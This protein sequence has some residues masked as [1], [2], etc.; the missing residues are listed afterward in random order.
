MWD[1]DIVHLAKFWYNRCRFYRMAHMFS[2][3]KYTRHDRMLSIPSL[4]IQTSVGSI[5]F[6]GNNT[7]IFMS[8]II[9]SLSIGSA[10]LS[11]LKDY[12]KFSKIETQHRQSYHGYSRL[13]RLIEKE[14]VLQRSGMESMDQKKFINDLCSQLELLSNDSPEIEE[15]ILN[16]V[17]GIET[18]HQENEL[19]NRINMSMEMDRM[20]IKQI[21]KKDVE[22][23]SD[24]LN[25]RNY[26]NV[27]SSMNIRKQHINSNESFSE[28]L[29]V[30]DK[31]MVM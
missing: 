3:Q 14:L 31:T 8:Y 15:S 27:V 10:M 28:T 30:D 19:I 24:F 5:S 20:T 11:A 26:N 16:K 12:L 23:V 29:N 7:L 6:S 9:G 17:K 2:A 22:K 18:S 21:Q 25:K 1:E 13:I 4:L